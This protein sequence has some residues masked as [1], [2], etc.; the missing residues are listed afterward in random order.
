MS[1]R[2]S[3]RDQVCSPSSGTAS[4]RCHTPVWRRSGWSP[5]RGTAVIYSRPAG[6]PLERLGARTPY[7]TRTRLWVRAR[8]GDWLK[9]SALTAPSGAGWISERRTRPAPRLVRRI[10]IDRSAQRLTV[11]GGGRRWS[12]K[13]VLG[14]SA[15]PTPLGTF[16][17][18]HRLARR[19]LSRHLRRVG[20][21]ALG[22]RVA[23][24][25]LA[26]GGARRAARGALAALE[27]RLHPGPG[28]A[29][30]GGSRAKQSPARRVR[31]R[32]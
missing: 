20:L 19:T 29:P 27:R 14:G 16:Q 11:Y 15:S 10:E 1:C 9:V 18:T 4:R 31:I 3:L 26:S 7:G 22:L 24:A 5:S 21:P 13:V 6:R 8:R 12:T 30:C 32:A 2:H 17:V 28:L 25:E 23:R